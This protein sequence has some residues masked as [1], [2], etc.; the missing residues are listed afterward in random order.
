M[1]MCQQLLHQEERT[2]DRGT[3]SQEGAGVSPFVPNAKRLTSLS[4]LV[5][6]WTSGL[7]EGLRVPGSS[8]DVVPHILILH[9]MYHFVVI[10]LYRPDL[11]DHGFT[12]DTGRPGA[13]FARCQEAA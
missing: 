13:L 3:T 5:D 2:L 6:Q 4:A 7:P 9:M 10:L 8:T 1:L 12:R 11:G